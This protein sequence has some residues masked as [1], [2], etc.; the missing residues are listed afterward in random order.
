MRVR[1]A[2]SNISLIRVDTPLLHPMCVVEFRDHSCS[3]QLSPNLS[4]YSSMQIRSSLQFSQEI[5][6]VLISVVSTSFEYLEIVLNPLGI[7][8]RLPFSCSVSIVQDFVRFRSL[9][10]I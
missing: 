6:I 9:V 5:H 3:I 7:F 2:S 8:S 1:L 4:V 10:G